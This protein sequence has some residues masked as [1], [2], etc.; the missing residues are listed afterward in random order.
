MWSKSLL[1]VH[2]AGKSNFCIRYAHLTWP[3]GC[4][5]KSFTFSPPFLW[6]SPHATAVR[7]A[8]L[9]HDTT[10]RSL[11]M[12]GSLLSITSS[13]T[14]SPTYQIVMTPEAAY[15]WRQHPRKRPGDLSFKQQTDLLMTPRVENIGRTRNWPRRCSNCRGF[16]NGSCWGWYSL[17]V[18]GPGKNPL[19][20]RVLSQHL[21]SE[22]PRGSSDTVRQLRAPK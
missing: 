21:F 1:L 20:T 5:S 16:K 13:I 15:F 10:W 7:G 3:V 9:G 12:I 19:A 17:P 6:G 11:E 8:S 22:A 2:L 4:L 18:A 14:P